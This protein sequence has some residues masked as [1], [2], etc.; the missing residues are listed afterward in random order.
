[1]YIWVYICT[2][3]GRKAVWLG[4]PFG[5][6]SEVKTCLNAKN[7]IM[8]PARISTASSLFWSAC[9]RVHSSTTHTLTTSEELHG[10][11][12]GLSTWNFSSFKWSIPQPQPIMYTH[13]NPQPILW[14][15]YYP[16][17]FQITKIWSTEY[18]LKELFDFPLIKTVSTQDS[19]GLT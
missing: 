13:Q 15:S 5:S 10:Q 17:S 7:F 4:E 18:C 16:C 1:M 2:L 8:R 12:T 11:I 14:G 3:W 9:P 6:K 19:L